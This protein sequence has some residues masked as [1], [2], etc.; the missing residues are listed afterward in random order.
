MAAARTSTPLS[1]R[2]TATGTRNHLPERL[3]GG[4][5]AV[6]PAAVL[7]SVYRTLGGVCDII[8]VASA[9]NN[10]LVFLVV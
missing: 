4:A 10:I 1:R 2:A 3:L 8:V 9:L 6:L 5:M 7:V